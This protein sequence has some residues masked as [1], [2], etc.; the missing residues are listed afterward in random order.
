MILAETDR[1]AEGAPDFRDTGNKR[2][3]LNRGRYVD[4][5]LSTAGLQDKPA[6]TRKT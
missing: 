1:R 4:S 6:R 5:Q 3:K 2:V